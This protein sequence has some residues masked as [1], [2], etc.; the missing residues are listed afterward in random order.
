MVVC[1]SV[2]VFKFLISSPDIFLS[3][4]LKLI[5]E[6]DYYLLEVNTHENNTHE[7]YLILSPAYL[8]ASSGAL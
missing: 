2:Y 6:W 5:W 8:M 1:M 4:C 7:I 3:T